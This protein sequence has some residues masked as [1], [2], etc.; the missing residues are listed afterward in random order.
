MKIKI[1]IVV[2]SVVAITLG[3]TSFLMF[4]HS[5]VD[6]GIAACE[7]IRDHHNT[8]NA[9]I[10]QDEYLAGRRAI[11]RSRYEDL[12]STGTHLIDLAW[13]AQGAQ[14]LSALVLVGPL[15]NAYSDFSGACAAH[16]IVLPSILDH[17]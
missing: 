5:P 7:R 13:Q 8:T 12:R 11:A 9:K 16:N 1:A 10:T 3:I 2:I 14:D 6:P 4:H 17:S 15:M